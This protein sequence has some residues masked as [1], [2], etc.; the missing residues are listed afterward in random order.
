MEEFIVPEWAL[1]PIYNGEN[2][3]LDLTKEEIA[4]AISFT[5]KH[6]IDPEFTVLSPPFFS[7]KNDITNEGGMCVTLT[8]LK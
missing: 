3:A 6:N 2:T 8:K 5:E 4:M 7:W 1:G